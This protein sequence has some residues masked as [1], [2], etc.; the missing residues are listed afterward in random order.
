[1]RET[2]R[3]SAEKPVALAEQSSRPPDL[4]FVTSSG[5]AFVALGFGAGLSP[6][7]PGTAG[8]LLGLVLAWPLQW[9]PGYVQILL[10]GAGFALGIAVCERAGRDLASP[11]CGAIVWDEVIGM[12]AV[13][14]LAPSGAT[15]LLASFI[16]FRLFDILK[17]WP[18]RLIDRKLRN[19]FG[20]MLDDA[21][22]A[23]YAIAAISI[24]NYAVAGFIR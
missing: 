7:W 22:A 1:M 15:W 17:P 19:G 12:A 18:I 24:L 16:A 10:I 14:L 13:C 4:R 5:Y 2:L 20:V 21:L 9:L 6:I 3:T 23:S 11:D 8:S